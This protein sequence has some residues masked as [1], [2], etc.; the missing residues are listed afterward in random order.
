MI[1][2]RGIEWLLWNDIP[3]NLSAGEYWELLTELKDLYK[4]EFIKTNQN[5]KQWLN[6][7]KVINQQLLEL[8]QKNT[9]LEQRLKSIQ[10]KIGTK[11]TLKERIL[12]TFD[13]KKR[14]QSNI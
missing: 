9:D 8:K 4:S 5:T 10:L 2:T 11:L 12:G 7:S 6:D 14:T 3:T 1:K 13:L